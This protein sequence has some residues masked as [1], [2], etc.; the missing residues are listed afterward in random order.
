[1]LKD[2]KLIRI[3]SKVNKNVKK[4]KE[5]QQIALLMIYEFLFAI[6]SRTLRL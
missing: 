3:F 5:S 6:S 1:M 2:A 4:I